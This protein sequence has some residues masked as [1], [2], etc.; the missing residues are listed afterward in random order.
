MLPIDPWVAPR[1]PWRTTRDIEIV[2]ADVD[3]VEGIAI[4]PDHSIWAG[5]ESGQIYRSQAGGAWRVIA[6]LPGRTLGVALDGDGV[7]YWCDMTDPGV[8]RVTPEGE[9]DLYSRGAPDRP[10]RVPNYPAFLPGGTLIVSDSGDWDEANGAIHAIHP[11]GTAFVLSDRPSS[12]PN[13]LCVSADGETIYICETT[14]SKVSMLRL[15]P[16]GSVIG[17]EDLI[18]LPG[19]LPDGLALDV[20]GR[21]YIACYVP[22]AIFALAPD[23]DLE[24]VLHDPQRILVNEPTNIA[25]RGPDRRDLVFAN[26]GDRHVGSV[27]LDVTGLAPHTPK[28]GRS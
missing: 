11:D 28:I 14:A 13:G 10:F 24:L 2:M 12:F 4:A 7:A 3:H 16:T 17:Y 20:E 18:H 6:T 5:G 27:R 15:D 21:L 22:D 8:Y 1:G 26:L 23:G 19:T 25:F 9:V